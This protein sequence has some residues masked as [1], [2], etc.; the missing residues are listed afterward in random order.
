MFFN[1]DKNHPSVVKKLQIFDE[2][3]WRDIPEEW[4]TKEDEE[5]YNRSV[6]NEWIRNPR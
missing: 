5:E 3:K 2:N 4:A 1:G 6:K